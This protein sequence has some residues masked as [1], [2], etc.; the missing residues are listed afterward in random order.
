MT[1]DASGKQYV[2]HAPK[3][4]SLDIGSP[5]YYR[6]M[7]VG[8]SLRFILMKT[9]QG[10]T[11]RIF[12]NAPYDGLV[13]TNTRFWHTSGFDMQIGSGGFSPKRN[14]SLPLC[15]GVSFSRRTKIPVL[16]RRRIPRSPWL[17]TML[18]R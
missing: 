17:Q 16:K 14:R 5:V 7:K 2:L 13:G 9:M 11:V 3:L 12:V 6:R 18:K 8:Q 15:S 10:I 1:R 4:G